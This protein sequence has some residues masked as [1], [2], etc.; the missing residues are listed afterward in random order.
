MAKAKN[1]LYFLF[2]FC[3]ALVF[4]LGGGGVRGVGGVLF[5]FLKHMQNPYPFT[6]HFSET[7]FNLN[8]W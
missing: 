4:C 8:N 7:Q 3:F 2:G 1:K 6:S 5:T